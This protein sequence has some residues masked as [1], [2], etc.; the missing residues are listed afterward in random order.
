[1]TKKK[2]YSYFNLE[3]E[4]VTVDIDGERIVNICDVRCTLCGCKL[5]VYSGDPHNV[6]ECPNCGEYD[7]TDTSEKAI[8][9]AIN[10]IK[11][12]INDTIRTLYILNNKLNVYSRHKNYVYEKNMKDR[13][14][15]DNEI[16]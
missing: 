13:A 11:D 14:E 9:E 8:Q 12:Q 6:A 16:S 7:C 1:M 15:K 5:I 3:N 4:R 2:T 10:R